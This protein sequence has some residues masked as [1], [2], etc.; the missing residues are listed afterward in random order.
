MSPDRTQLSAWLS[1]CSTLVLICATVLLV[2]CGTQVGPLSGPA[3]VVLTETPPIQT[4]YTPNY[5]EV[6]GT[7][8]AL[9]EEAI[10]TSVA[11][12][13]VPTWTPG[14]PPSEPTS[15]P[16]LGLHSGC[17]NKNSLEPFFINCWGGIVNGDYI[18]VEVGREGS[19]G[20][21][22]Q[23]VIMVVNISQQS[24]EMYRTPQRV[25]PVRIVEVDGTRFT[26]A[27][28]DY[29]YFETPGALQTPWATT[30]PGPVFVF[31]IATRQ[32]VSSTPVPTPFPSPS[33]SASPSP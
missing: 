31:D 16:E 21:K 18:D 29:Y 3:A 27:P 5:K 9:T 4:T 10:R 32:W 28:I 33:V 13:G 1:L 14:I 8:I 17:S 15:T 19:L 30:T 24:S 6:A 20:D 22:Q 7:E 23:G 12:T 26:L 2:A 11:L 25:G